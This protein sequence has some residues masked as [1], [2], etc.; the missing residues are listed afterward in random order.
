MPSRVVWRRVQG[1]IGMDALWRYRLTVCVQTGWVLCAV[2]LLSSCSWTLRGLDVQ[3]AVD[4][5]A[6]QLVF[7]DPYSPIARQLQLLLTR[8]GW[9]VMPEAPWVLQLDAEQVT[10]RPVAVTSLGE[11]AQYQLQVTLL[12]RLSA[13]GQVSSVPESLKAVRVFDFVRGGHLASNDE[14]QTLLTE[15]RE[16]LAD[17]LL[18]RVQQM[19]HSAR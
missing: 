14:E 9:P 4:K 7:F 12:Y 18:V 15:M 11:A 17:R 2:C 6:L 5:P 1:F 8:R 13:S 10:K 16:E 3:Q 19:S